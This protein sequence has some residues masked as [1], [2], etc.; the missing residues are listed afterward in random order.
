MTLAGLQARIEL[1]A[2]ANFGVQLGDVKESHYGY[3]ERVSVS[4]FG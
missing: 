2:F 1:D 4:V 3:L